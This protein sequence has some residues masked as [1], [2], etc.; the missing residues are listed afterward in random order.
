MLALIYG[1]HKSVTF[2]ENIKGVSGIYCA[3]HRSTGICYVG[4]SLDIHK[5]RKEH[6][7]KSRRGG[8]GRFQRA[9]RE[10]GEMEFDF[11]ILERCPKEVL[12]ERER[13]YIALMGAAEIDG[14]NSREN[15]CATYT[16]KASDITRKRIS[17]SKK[18]AIR[19]PEHRLAQSIGQIGLKKDD[20]CKNKISA[21][22]L[23]KA[24]SE[25]SKRKLA[26]Y[27]TGKKDTEETRAK[28]RAALIGR[29]FGPD[30][31]AKQQET[32]R[33]KTVSL[34]PT[35]GDLRKPIVVTDRA[36]CVLHVFESL[37]E[38]VAGLATPNSSLRYYLRTEKL[39]PSGMFLHYATIAP[40]PLAPASNIPAPAYPP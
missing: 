35:Y 34:G 37:L 33:A 24:K 12:L 8:M 36:G 3:I 11:E 6:L 23:G 25:E 28:K 16:Y 10:F 40:A 30:S 15:P 14:L 19:K 38:T 13:F 27:R 1:H 20:D 21:A 2:S 32:R 18:G 26:E 31:I 22:L 39:T 17:E 5:R 29:V 9:L 7:Q 4:S